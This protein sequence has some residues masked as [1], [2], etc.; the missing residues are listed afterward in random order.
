M[1]LRGCRGDDICVPSELQK[2]DYIL[3]YSGAG[4][5]YK[6]GSVRVGWDGG[7]RE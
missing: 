6:Y 5:I 2:L 3:A 1:V 4:T 7:C